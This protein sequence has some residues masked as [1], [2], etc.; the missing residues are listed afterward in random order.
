[1]NASKY[2]FEEDQALKGRI[3][4]LMPIIDKICQESSSSGLSFGI[5]HHGVVIHKS[6]IVYRE[7]ES[8]QRPDSNT[9]YC[10]NSM[11]KAL[12]AAAIGV[13]VEE[14]KL[15]WDTPVHTI[16]PEFGKGHGSIGEMITIVDLLSH[17]SRI[18]SPDT[19]FSK[20]TMSYY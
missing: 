6:D 3:E 1:M 18:A 5:L 8:R 2:S 12:T 19:F 15:H 14:R 11:T 10:I 16:I 17:R 4:S 7:V 20:T 13:L 9:L